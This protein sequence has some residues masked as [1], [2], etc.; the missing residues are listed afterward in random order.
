M[1][2]RVG[3][4]L[5]ALLLCALITACAS[6]G[7]PRDDLEAA[8]ARRAIDGPDGRSHAL[9]GEATFYAKRFHGRPTACGEP[10]DMRAFTAAHKTLPFHTV[11][12]VRDPRTM[13]SV[14]VRIN[15]RGPFKSGRVIDLSRA[16]AADL[17]MIETGVLLVELE[18]ISWGDG[19]RCK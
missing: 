2:R 17:G 7:D 9:G 19:S 12:R 8:L 13:K 3:P 18:V 1:P 15:D 10:F 16:A 11:V 14:V 4:K 5:S 6:P